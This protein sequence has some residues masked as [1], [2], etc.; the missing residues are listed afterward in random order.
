[1]LVMSFANS[2]SVYPIANFAASL[3]I[4]YPVALLANALDRDTRGFISTTIMS[5]LAG[6]I[7]NWILLPPV[8]T[9]TARMTAIDASRIR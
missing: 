6:S 5:P 3:A 1:M 8:S 7:A 2:S 4:G 9:P